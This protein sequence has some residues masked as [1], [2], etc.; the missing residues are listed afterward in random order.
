MATASQLLS[1]ELKMTIDLKYEAQAFCREHCFVPVCIEQAAM[2]RGAALA[3]EAITKELA[4]MRT[5]MNRRR[6]EIER[7]H[8]N[9]WSS[10]DL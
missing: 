9:S 5:E 4:A 3:A 7:G 2:E 6:D 1:T 8:G 10:L